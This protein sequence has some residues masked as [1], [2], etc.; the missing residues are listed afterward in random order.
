MIHIFLLIAFTLR[1][2]QNTK[3]T[4][5]IQCI[6]QCISFLFFKAFHMCYLKVFNNFV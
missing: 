5:F 2:F 1:F 6:I 4:R 3:N